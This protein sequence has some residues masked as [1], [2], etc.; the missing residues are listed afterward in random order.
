MGSDYPSRSVDKT[1]PST[2]LI[3]FRRAWRRFYSLTVGL[4][5][6]GSKW[7]TCFYSS[8]VLEFAEEFGI[9]VSYEPLVLGERR[10]G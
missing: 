3:A 4:A 6:L 5:A 7:A 10:G 8:R 2:R 9:S 1:L